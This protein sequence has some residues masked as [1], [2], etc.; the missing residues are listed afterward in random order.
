M[1]GQLCEDTARKWPLLC[2]GG[3]PQGKP[4]CRYLDLGHV[5]LGLLASMTMRTDVSVAKPLS[6]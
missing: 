4:I 5:D 1:G 2:E 6:L 3:R